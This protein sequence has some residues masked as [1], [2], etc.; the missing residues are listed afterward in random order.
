[1]KKRYEFG[2]KEKQEISKLALEHGHAAAVWK[3]KEKFPT[4]TESTIRPW[5]K[6]FKKRKTK[7]E[8]K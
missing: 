8:R 4:L 5:I 6:K 1:M 7:E 3:F 2:G